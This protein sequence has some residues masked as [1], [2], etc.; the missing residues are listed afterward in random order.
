[1]PKPIHVSLIAIPE[2]SISTL[3]GLYDVLNG[4]SLLKGF[5]QAIPDVPPFQVDI[6]GL[7]QGPVLLASGLQAHI[8][9][10]IQDVANTDIVIVPSVILTREGW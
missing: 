4:F 8:H 2:A 3:H 1:M 9:R 5:D 10:G 6:V 7:E